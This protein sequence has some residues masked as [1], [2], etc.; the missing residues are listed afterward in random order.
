MTRLTLLLAV[1]PLTG[2]IADESP[3]NKIGN[4]DIERI[5][6]G[7]RSN[8]P[9]KV[10]VNWMTKEPGD[11]IVRFGRTADY[12]QEVRVANETTIH[13]VEIP[14]E[15]TGGVYHYSV[16]TGNQSSKDAT[17]KAY[18]SDELRVAVAADWQGLPDLSAVKKDDVHLLLTAGDNISNTHQL[19]GAGNKGSIK[20]YARLIDRYPELFRSVPFMPALGNHDKQMRPRGDKPPEQPVYDIEATSFRRFFEL[21]GEEW[22]WHFDVPGFDVRFAALDLHHISD[23]GSAWQSCHLFGKDSE[24]FRWYDKLMGENKRKFVVT[25][26]NERN[27]S[28]RAQEKGAWHSLFRKGTIA[29]TGFGYYAERAE[30]DDFTYYN[31]SL[32]G[33][34]NQYPDPKSAF[35]K[36]ADSYILLALT[37]DPAKMVVEIKGLDGTVLDRK[38]YP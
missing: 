22:K 24:Q 1:L 21:P 9:S 37:K 12:G 25:L 7:H 8:N 17:F 29:I 19:G 16:H 34:G 28:M 32:S 4:P 3:T 10:V 36:G 26:Y 11:S 5:W 14:L 33:K 2:L 13:H 27:G 6:L 31:T 20:A 15:D 35:L 30:V 23:L 18:P 38:V